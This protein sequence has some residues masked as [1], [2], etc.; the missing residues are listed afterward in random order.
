M[1]V[2]N[3]IHILS[4]T[5]S[6]WRTEVVKQLDWQESP[7]EDMDMSY[8][9]HRRKLGKLAYAAK[10]VVLT[11]EPTSLRDYTHQL[12]RWF[13]GYWLTTA[14]YKTPFGRQSL[15]FGQAVFLA[16]GAWTFA[17]LLALPFLFLHFLPVWFVL[18][19]VYDVCFLVVIVILSARLTRDFRPILF[20]P[21]LLLLYFYDVV[22][23]FVSFLSYRKLTT[24]LWVS[25]ERQ[26]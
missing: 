24:G 23:N 12:T 1:E 20:L 5:C 6:I 7:V 18:A 2:F 9:I 21:A 19:Y 16:E 3:T 4:G 22:L 17:R 11:Q 15:D 25:P 8:Q 13:R 10:A 14:K 26:P